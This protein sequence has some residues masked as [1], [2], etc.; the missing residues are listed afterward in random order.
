MSAQAFS[1]F[2]QSASVIAIPRDALMR[3]PDGRTMVWVVEETSEQ[4]T[5]SARAVTAGRAEG[6]PIR[7]TSGLREG[8]RVVVRG[9]ESLRAG[10][11]VRVVG[12][13][14]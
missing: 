9:N 2:G 10:Q 14:N 13:D 6:D 11:P 4:P 5:V 1:S 3:Q 7:I 8:D 12:D